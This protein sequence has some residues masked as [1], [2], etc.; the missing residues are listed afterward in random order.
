MH[1]IQWGVGASIALLAISA[2]AQENAPPRVGAGADGFSFRS[3]DGAW[4]LRLRG[5]AQIDGRAFDSDSAAPGDNEWLLRRVRPTLEGTFGERV[6][7]RLMPDFGGGRTEI[8]DAWVDLELADD[9]PVI[10]AGKFKPPVGLE[11]LRSANHLQLVERSIV[12]ELVP[13]RD[14]GVQISGTGHGLEWQ[15]GLFNGVVD[16]SSGDEDPDGKQDFAAR[17]FAQPFAGSDGDGLFKGLGLGVAGTYGS[18]DGTPTT[19]LLPGYRTPGQKVMFSYRTGAEGTFATG[20]RQRLSPQFY[21]YR[22]PFGLMGERVRVSQDVRRLLAGTD[23]TDT[24]DHDAWQLTFNW[25]LTGET[26]GFRDPNATGAIEL[27]ARVS[28]FEAD[29]DSFVGGAQ[30]FADPATA[31]RRADTRAIGVNWFPVAGIKASLSYQQTAFAGGSALGDRT[32]E[33]VLLARLQLYF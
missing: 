18:M 23:R 21:W 17:I 19:P 1:A 16:G 4:T 14:I 5:L 28:G 26:A 30:S 20:E 29:A 15:T 10:R 2:A 12:T 7:F 33:R 13:R 32:D 9:G 25:F 11:R 3:G 6:A 31:V 22:G 27:V 8:P 24:L